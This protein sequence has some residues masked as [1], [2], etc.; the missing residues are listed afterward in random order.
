LTK[1][2]RINCQSY[3]NEPDYFAGTSLI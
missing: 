2:V 1:N 3:K